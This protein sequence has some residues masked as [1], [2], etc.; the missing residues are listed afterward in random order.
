MTGDQ[1]SAVTL[2]KPGDPARPVPAG[3]VGARSGRWVTVAAPLALVAL[4]A[5]WL[6]LGA[7]GVRTV[8]VWLA[9]GVLALCLG[10]VGVSVFRAG[11]ARDRTYARAVR[12]A[13]SA[14][15]EA[16]P[17]AVPARL[18]GTPWPSL[19]A[20]GLLVGLPT[21]VCLWIALAVAE[22]DSG[23]RA[24][25]LREAGAVTGK[26]RIAAIEHEVTEG[27]GRNADA[28]AQ[29]TVLLPPA[30]G[31]GGRGVPASFTADTERRQEV[32]GELYVGYVPAHPELG[33]V[34]DDQR[35]EVERKL[36]GRTVEA[37]TSWVAAGFW[38]LVTLALCAGW[39]REGVTRRGARSTGE[40]WVA[41]RVRVTGGG[42]HTDAP[43]VEGT[44]QAAERQ[45]RENTRQLKCL[46]LGVDGTDRTVP[47]H[48]ELSSTVAGAVL[49]GASGLLVWH[50]QRRRGKDVLAELIG[51][52][53]WQLPGAVPAR[54]AQG[55]E[56]AAPG[57][58]RG[59]LPGAGRQVR[60]LDLGAAW[61][62]TV[63]KPL[64]AGLVCALLSMGALLAVPDNGAWRLWV[65]AA[66]LLAP[67]A[68][69]LVR[70]S[71]TAPDSD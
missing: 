68:A 1:P 12:A 45:R 21:L 61:S 64:L 3:A 10:A 54:V 65:G 50:P 11:A 57:P 20:V 41:L 16:R 47:F 5:A 66:G 38:I 25:A 17:A 44:D 59:A 63:P 4:T 26:L 30:N 8:V 6:F 24:A 55:M 48:G 36:S 67:L 58:D 23:G 35:A 43:P 70:T 29:Y 22:P 62:A 14:S 27:R 53:G 15:G 28:T 60:L 39:W 19:R 31:Q 52:D 71:R 18:H 69:L 51:D 34:G 2:S 49:A 7:G 33:A 42:K 13:S 37:A 9:F 46:L 56:A 40:D 32:G